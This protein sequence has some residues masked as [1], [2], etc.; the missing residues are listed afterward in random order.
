MWLGEGAFSSLLLLSPIP[1]KTSCS[2]SVLCV[3]V[4][5]WVVGGHGLC[6][7]CVGCAKL[8]LLL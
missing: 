1:T 2:T 6:G 5:G 8:G 4:E 3:C 7:I